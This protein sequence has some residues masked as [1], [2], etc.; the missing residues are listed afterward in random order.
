MQDRKD[1]DYGMTDMGVREDD[2]A[3]WKVCQSKLKNKADYLKKEKS[4]YRSYS[5]S[6]LFFREKMHIASQMLR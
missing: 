1:R 4:S 2:Q 6:S 3:N 5:S